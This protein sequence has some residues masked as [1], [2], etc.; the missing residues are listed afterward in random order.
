M[1]NIFIGVRYL[2]K[3]STHIGLLLEKVG[4]GIRPFL[5]TACTGG[6]QL[7]LEEKGV[8]C[9]ANILEYHYL[10]IRGNHIRGSTNM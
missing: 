3:S 9:L 2:I 6:R 4:E 1:Q 5:M 10:N 8:V 7:F